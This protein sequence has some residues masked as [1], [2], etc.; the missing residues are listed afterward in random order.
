MPTCCNS[1]C[2]CA[3]AARVA[4]VAR[5]HVAPANG[6]CVNAELTVWAAGIHGPA[7]LRQLDGLELSADGRLL[8][9]PSLQTTL[10]PRVFALGDCAHCVP[11]TGTR[12]I[13]P[14]AQAA[15]QQ[16]RF[17]V[18]ALRRRLKGRALPSF[19][20]HD[21]GVL[22]AIGRLGAA[23]G[24]GI[25]LQGLIARWTYRAVQRRHLLALYGW[26]RTLLVTLAGR[27]GGRTRPRLKLH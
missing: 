5:D 25:K 18:H 19:A 6:E 23:N 22:L 10:D 2:A 14:R 26:T 21:G 7:V 16:A 24:R 17:L 4:E 3:W 13:P 8:V 9:T 12:P 20:F 11:R 1:A 27:L 15:Q